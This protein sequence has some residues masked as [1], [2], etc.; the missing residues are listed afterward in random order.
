MFYG[1]NKM[2]PMRHCDHCALEWA[3]TELRCWHCGRFSPKGTMLPY[4]SSSHNMTFSYENEEEL[5]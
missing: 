1:V 4:W 3:A 2:V 5:V